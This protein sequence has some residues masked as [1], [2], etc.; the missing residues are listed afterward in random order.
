VPTP[1]QATEGGSSHYGPGL[2]GDF[3]VAVA[4]DPGLY[5]R[6]DFYYYAS[7]MSRERFVEVGQL[8]A[9][10]ET[11]VGMYMLTGLMVL[12]KEVLSA[13]YALGI[14]MPITYTNLSA[15]VSLGTESVS[16]DDDLTTTADIGIIPAS[17]FWNSGAWHFNLYEAISVPTGTYNVNRDLNGGLN[18]WTFDTVLATTYMMESTGSEF[19]AVPGYTFHTKND[20]TDYKSGQEF[21]LDLML[22]QFISETFGVGLQGFYYKQVTGDSG[23]GALLG[24]FKGEAAGIGP[25]VMWTTSLGNAPLILTAKWLHEFH[26]EHRLEGENLFLSV[27]L[28]L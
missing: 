23:G 27:T 17:L 16:I 11:D 3:G 9:N 26:T 10:L 8:R 4:P 18:Y 5:L 28:A 20:E 15:D 24:D 2:N 22:N 6:S 1:A 19:S 14:I 25:A 7:N 12:D 21:H 13:R